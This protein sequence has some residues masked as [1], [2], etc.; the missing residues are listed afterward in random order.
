MTSA[1]AALG[2]LGALGAIL[3]RTRPVVAAGFAALG[4][5]ELLLARE[6]L[7]GGLGEQLDSASGVA[8][9]AL[10]LPF[11]VALAAVFVRYPG[12]IIPAVVAAAPFRFPFEID[13]GN[14]FLVGLGEN[15]ALGR[16]VPLYVIVAAAALALVWRL[17][18][19]DPARPLP[20]VLAVPAGLLAALMFLSA[21]WSHDEAATVDRLTFFILPFVALLAVVARAPFRSW[22]PRVLLI[23]TLAL[24]SLFAV[25][26]LVEW[27]T[28]SLL[29]YDPKVAVAN[30]YSNFFRVTSLFSDPSIYAR[31]VAVA[32]AI[33]VVCLWLG[34][35]GVLAGIALTALLFAGLFV[36]YSQ[37]S[38]VA[39]TAAVLVVTYLA[40]DKAM[41]RA[42]VLTAAVLV[43]LGAIGFGGLLAA[44]FD[45]GRVT[46][47]RTS[48][49]ADTWEVFEANP[50]E[51]VGIAAQPEASRDL[52][53]G[54]RDVRRNASH[55]APVTIAAEFGIIGLALYLALLA[56]TLRLLWLVRARDEALGLSLLAA[57][58]VLFVHSLSYGVFF[59]DPLV[60]T[61]LGVACAALGTSPEAVRVPWPGRRDRHTVPAPA[62]R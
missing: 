18:R 44:G 46:S 60:W 20:L 4:A 45:A 19:G 62:A 25:V 10:G 56:A 2:A 17:A 21:L 52:S 6:L 8:A 33:L 37:S 53:E 31:H 9:L 11:L 36:S 15:G 39:L 1:A 38:M 50:I 23:E 24:A 30:A 35:I 58:L 7:P 47:G 12:G 16:L 55:T 14:R 34:R 32:L 27:S 41:R 61:I 22:L 42:L 40:A 54:P 48:L 59:E 29:F 13:S 3:G 57:I 26:G 43:T 51:G 28:R 5:A 49:V